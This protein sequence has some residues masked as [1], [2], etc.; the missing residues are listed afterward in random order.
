[1]DKLA[2]EKLMLAWFV[3]YVH[4]CC[5]VTWAHCC[6]AFTHHFHPWWTLKD[7]LRLFE[8][9][10]FVILYWFSCEWLNSVV[11]QLGLGN[12][13]VLINYHYRNSTMCNIFNQYQFLWCHMYNI[14]VIWYCILQRWKSFAVT[15]L[16]FN[17]LENICGWM[18]VLHGKTYCTGYFTGKVSRYGSIRENHETFP[19]QTICNIQYTA[20]CCNKYYM[21]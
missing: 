5:V 21:T 4:L 8:S 12:I 20:V 10:L 18:V 13:S 19:P 17:L 7:S 16:N 15:E 6:F 14:R 2:V 9:L 11:M 1:M 3:L